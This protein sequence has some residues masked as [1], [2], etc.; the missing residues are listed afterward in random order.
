MSIGNMLLPEMALTAA[1]VF[2]FLALAHGRLGWAAAIGVFAV[3][4]K[5]TGLA[6]AAAVGV[7]VLYDAWERGGVFSKDAIRRALV[8]AV[9]LFALLAF[10]AFQKASVGY[11]VFPHHA[12]LLAERPFGPTSLFTV[13]PSLFFWHGRWIV[14]L[15]ALL[16]AWLG[17]SALRAALRNTELERDARWVPSRRALFIGFATLVLLNTLF[18]S[19]MFWLERYVLPAHPVVLLSAGF[20]LVVGL[21]HLPV[22]SALPFAV[23]TAM[24]LAHLWAPTGP[25][26]EELTFAYAHVIATHREA[27]TAVAAGDVEEAHVLSTWPMTIELENPYLGYVDRAVRATNVRYLDGSHDTTFTHVL[28]SNASSRAEALRDEAEARYMARV[29]TFRVGSAPRLELYAR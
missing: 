15:A 17:G 13:F 29:G 8:A 2:A 27:F 18:F 5:E 16:A 9:P 14:T 3:L 23:A 10:F 26:Q 1:A 11:F 22:L 28:V 12:S 4:I 21:E 7:V 20:I 24:G 25:D 6:G 19:K